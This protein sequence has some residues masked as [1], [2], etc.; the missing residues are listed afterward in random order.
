MGDFSG[1][2]SA[3]IH[4]KHHLSLKFCSNWCTNVRTDRICSTLTKNAK[5]LGQR[6]DTTCT[7]AHTFTSSSLVR[8]S[9]SLKLAPNERNIVHQCTSLARRS[10]WCFWGPQLP[11]GFTKKNPQGK[12]FLREASGRL[13]DFYVRVRDLGEGAYG[14]VFL[15]RQRILAGS[16]ERD[17]S[18]AGLCGGFCH[19]LSHLPKSGRRMRRRTNDDHIFWD[20]WG[21]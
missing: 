4:A 13:S 12:Q 15:A 3:W 16:H 19:V 20:L 2:W 9:S 10:G 7:S 6:P 1:E 14:E 5:E 17:W 21:G 11:T 8:L 18:R